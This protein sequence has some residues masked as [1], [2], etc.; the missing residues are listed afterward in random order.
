MIPPSQS[1]IFSEERDFVA[2]GKGGGGQICESGFMRPAFNYGD[3]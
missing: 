3:F 1:T 2:V